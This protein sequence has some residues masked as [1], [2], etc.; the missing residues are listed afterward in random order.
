MKS[1]TLISLC[2]NPVRNPCHGDTAASVV[3]VCGVITSMDTPSLV[4][5][6][7]R[8]LDQSQHL[9]RVPGDHEFLVGG[10]HPGRHAAPLARDSWSFTRVRVRIE[11]DT[12]PRRRVANPA[13]D[14]GGVLA[15]A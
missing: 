2:H 10:N 3:F 13:A 14:L 15:N 4:R 9:A 11:I 7:D 8:R 1:R 5:L 6:R 12:E